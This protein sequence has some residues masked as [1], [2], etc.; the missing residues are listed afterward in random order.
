M[1]DPF[2]QFSDLTR[3]HANAMAT[4]GVKN[5]DGTISTVRTLVVN[6]D[7]KEV[8]I[9]SVWDG[10]IVDDDEAVR[11]SMASGK[12]WPRFDTVEEAEAA[13]REWHR[14]LGLIK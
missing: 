4:G 14:Y 1:P 8:I 11:R 10:Q 7:G 2:E 13:D 6:L 3:H 9:P 12:D 5:P